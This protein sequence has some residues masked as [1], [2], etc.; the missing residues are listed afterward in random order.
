MSENREETVRHFCDVTGA[1]ETRSK[2]FLESSNW[3]LEEAISSFFEHGG[4]VDEPLSAAPVVP[5]VPNLSDSDMESPPDSP[6]K[7]RQQAK[8]K[9]NSN[10][11]TLDSLQVEE[12]S[13]DEEEGQAFYAG[14]SERSGQQIIGPG[15]GRK[16][17]VTEVFKS[18]KERGAV[19]FEDEP[20][21]SGRG[22]GVV[23]GGTGYR[24]GQTADDHET[25]TPGGAAAPTQVILL[26]GL[27]MQI[28]RKEGWRNN[29]TPPI[30]GATVPIAASTED[31]AANQRAAQE[32]VKLDE[33]QPTTTIQ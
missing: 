20:S 12:M 14:G 10:F 3:R 2:F 13:S 15:K 29:P 17:I 31:S 8:K 5:S 24:L 1:D 30:V 19:V 21:S 25:V 22:R 33:T 26:R 4:N 18:V 7:T 11:A 23:F 28:R 16:D 32:A 9:P 27:S 6:P